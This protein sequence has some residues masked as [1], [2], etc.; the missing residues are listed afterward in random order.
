MVVFRYFS[1]PHRSTNWISRSLCSWIFC[2]SAFFCA[3]VLTACVTRVWPFSP[4]GPCWLLRSPWLPPDCRVSAVS[5]M[6]TSNFCSGDRGCSLLDVFAFCFVFLLPEAEL[7]SRVPLT[8]DDGENSACSCSSD[9][10]LTVAVIGDDAPASPLGSGREDP[11]LAAAVD[12]EEL[13]T[14]SQ[15]GASFPVFPSGVDEAVAGVC[16]PWPAAVSGIP[17]FSAA[18]ERPVADGSAVDEDDEEELDGPPLADV[19]LD[20]VAADGRGG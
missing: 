15:P 20:E 9:V 11:V 3:P 13:P 7:A 8:R 12:D 19:E 18:D 10:L 16:T 17:T 6:T 5:T 4:V 14:S 1:W 2:H